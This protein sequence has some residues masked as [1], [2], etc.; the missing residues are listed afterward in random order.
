MYVYMQAEVCE[1][2]KKCDTNQTAVDPACMALVP[3]PLADREPFFRHRLAS[4]S[5][6]QQLL[7]VWRSL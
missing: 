4:W 3:E 7:L 1:L 6:W 2:Q 5:L